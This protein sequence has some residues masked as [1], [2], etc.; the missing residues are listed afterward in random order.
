MAKPRKTQIHSSNLKV[1][2]FRGENDFTSFYPAEILASDVWL[3]SAAYTTGSLTIN[4]G[5]LVMAMGDFDYISFPLNQN[6]VDV[7]KWKIIR[8]I[9]QLEKEWIESQMYTPPSATVSGGLTLEK[10]YS[11][12][13]YAASIGWS[14]T[15]GT[16]AI[17]TQELWKKAGAGIWEKVKDLTGTN[18]TETVSVAINTDTQFKVQVSS[19]AG[20]LIPSSITSVVFQ[21]KTGYCI[22]D[23]TPAIDSA[24]LH[25]A[26]LGFDT[27]A[28]RTFTANATAGKHLFYFVPKS[29]VASPY[30][31]P[32]AFYVG[33]FQGG[34]DVHKTDAIYTLGDAT[35]VE[36]VVYRSTQASLG[37]TTVTVQST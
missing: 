10:N 20:E 15:A 2:N 18:G 8:H 12:S 7:G 13:P 17:I 9:S 3:C 24:W 25:A 19:K 6:S 22:D 14:V 29:F 31:N 16:N 23:P 35:T 28:Y 34:F 37:S 26:T 36:Y 1:W 21:Y 32:P 30:L 33:G 4:P 27:D 11:A 5:D